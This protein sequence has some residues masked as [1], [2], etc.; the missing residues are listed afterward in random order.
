MKRVRDASEQ[1]LATLKPSFGDPRLQALLVRYKAR[2]FPGSLSEVERRVWEQY[3]ADRINATMPRFAKDLA[4][5]ASKFGHDDDKLFL[6]QE[7]QLWAESIM[8]VVD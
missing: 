4:A 1:D 6:I 7:L 5:A 8:P 3:R 2:N